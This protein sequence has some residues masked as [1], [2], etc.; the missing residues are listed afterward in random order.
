MKARG[1]AKHVGHSNRVSFDCRL[2]K[3]QPGHHRS[4]GLRK[5]SH[6]TKPS[7]PLSQ[8]EVA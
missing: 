5:P 1:P 3:D 4:L 7:Q 8:A 6:S 2:R